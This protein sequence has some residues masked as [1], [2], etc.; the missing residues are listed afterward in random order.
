MATDF[1]MTGMDN[2]LSRIKELK[3]DIKIKGGR[4]AL[5]K[6]SKI[7]VDAAKAN[8]QS[9]DDPETGRSIASN[10]AM[11]FSN[12][13]F[14]ATGD[15]GFNIGIRHGAVL[16]RGGD[17]SA[18]SPTPHWRLLE[19]GTEKMRAQPFFRRALEENAGKVV[20]TFAVEFE[21]AMGRALKRAAKGVK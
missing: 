6:A 14:K 4:A 13:L 5:R 21:K 18:N 2:V 19:F 9:I 1:A 7:V 17:T 11:K 15:V 20:S 10:V 12:K 8:A 16:K 3:S